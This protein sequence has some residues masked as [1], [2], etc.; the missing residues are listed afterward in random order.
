M[1]LI[2]SEKYN[3]AERIAQILSGG[4]AERTTVSSTPV[5]RWGTK[6][7]IGL[8][9]HVVEV[10]F[11][12]EYNDWQAVDPVELV[13]AETEK[14]TTA[15]R[16]VSAV[17]QLA[18]E[19]D[20]ITIATDFDR[21]GELIG[22]EAYEIV[23]RENSSVDVRRAR[24][25]SLTA[26]DVKDAFSDPEEIDFS[27]AAAGEARQLI[28]LRWG[29]SLTRYLTLAANHKGQ[30]ISVGRVQTPTLKLIV[31]REREIE[32]FEP[33]DY[34]EINGKFHQDTTTNTD[35]F[36]A[37]YFYLDD[38]ETEAERIWNEQT[39]RRIHQTIDS[40]STA[41]VTQVSEQKRTDTPPIPFNTT[42]YIKAANA[43]GFDAKPAMSIA[44]DLY[45]N[46]YITYPRTDN[47][48]Y[49]D[50]LDIQA[51]LSQLQQ[52]RSF[53]DDAAQLL[54]EDTLS[55][56]EGD[57]ET[58]DHPPI[59]PT[60]DMPSR[61]ELSN[62]EWKIYE[63][64]VRRFFATLA[65]SALWIHSRIDIEVENHTLKANGKR[66][67]KAGYHAVY[68][69][70]DTE[71]NRLPSVENR[72]SIAVSGAE[73]LEKQTQPPNRYGQSQLIDKMEALGLGTKS[74]RHNLIDKLYERDY[75]QSNPPEPTP[76][77][78]ALVTAVEEY[79]PPLATDQMTAQL[80]SNMTA[81][82][83]GESSLES[84]TEESR[85]MLRDVFNRLR[86]EE[87]AVGTTITDTITAQQDDK[88]SEEPTEED[89]I[90]DCP[91]CGEWLLPREGESG[92]KF[93]GCHGYPDCNYT[94][95]L[96][97]KGRVHLLD[98]ICDDHG[99]HR[100]KMIAGKKTHVFGCPQCKKQEAD[101]TADRIIGPCPN[102]TAG[103]LAIKRVQTGSRLVGCVEY[104]DCDYSVPL[105]RD[106]DV[107][108][109]EDY[110]DEHDLPEVQIE[111]DD[112][113]SP[114]KI[115]CPICNYLEYSS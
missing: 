107:A 99:L 11:S 62:S 93:V 92:S 22:K 56:T 98:K 6:R 80:E 109:T 90:G 69:Y 35:T 108:V 34:W 91:E 66:L 5:F 3:A 64:V 12:S 77:A 36:S 47:T 50:G 24:F 9:G 28:D 85:D 81:I 30:L 48:V 75:V 105:P 104:P 78:R 21:E 44:E 84:V 70:F 87:N 71:Q 31:D 37:Q 52:Q 102:C 1:E 74:T 100:V 7:C 95:P 114:W 57:T 16:I 2:I 17:R 94:L 45:D 38:D 113:D 20:R 41:T 115:G 55:P 72:D 86:G 60:E 68:P 27:L 39:A 26:S 73:L 8:A 10:D 23:R 53:A 13:E 59:H 29:A 89:A 15:D 40:A 82:A 25:S 4:S 76:L 83:A 111:K 63:L 54:A 96:P 112:Y 103:E 101:D 42:E 88:E 79:A 67:L 51:L 32:T 43:I 33:D 14:R 19:A 46:G 106:G 18:S 97:N 61:G 49:P 110:C 65:D 58:T